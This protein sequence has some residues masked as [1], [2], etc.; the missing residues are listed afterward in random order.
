MSKTPKTEPDDFDKLAMELWLAGGVATPFKPEDEPLR[1][2]IH[3]YPHARVKMTAR[4][5]REFVKARLD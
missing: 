5:I 1:G 3:I 4:L 2:E